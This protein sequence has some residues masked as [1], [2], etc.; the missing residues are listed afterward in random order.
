MFEFI[1]QMLDTERMASAILVVLVVGGGWFA[2]RQ[3]WPWFTRRVDK[4]LDSWLELKR[5]ELRIE[6][7]RND[8]YANAWQSNNERLSSMNDRLIEMNIVIQTMLEADK[9]LIGA[10]LSFVDDKQLSGKLYKIFREDG[11]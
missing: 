4:T 3:F 8:R 2:A 9:L 11:Q 10:L 1:L 7:E 5:E 6:A